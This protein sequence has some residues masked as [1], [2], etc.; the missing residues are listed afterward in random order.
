MANIFV[1]SK[2]VVLR[3]SIDPSQ[4]YEERRNIGKGLEG[5]KTIYI[6]RF[7]SK[8]YLAERTGEADNSQK[9]TNG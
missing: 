5:T 8:Y 4:Y 3:F 7:N 6:F 2:S 1:M 9:S